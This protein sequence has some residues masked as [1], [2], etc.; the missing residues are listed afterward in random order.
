MFK[1]FKP[2]SFVKPG[3]SS[4]L[5][6][7][8]RAVKRPRLSDEGGGTKVSSNANI[9][10]DRAVTPELENTNPDIVYYNVLW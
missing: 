8:Q 5:H 4:L 3:D 6:D 7:S 1:P 9:N 2:P 10:N